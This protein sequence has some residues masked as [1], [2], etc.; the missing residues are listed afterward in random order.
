MISPKIQEQIDQKVDMC[1][2]TVEKKFGCSFVRPTIKLDLN[3]TQFI[4]QAWYRKNLI[5]LNPAGFD[6]NTDDMI[7]DTLPHEIAH[8]VTDH[9]YGLDV[10]DH[11]REWKGVASMLGAIPRASSRDAR[12][13]PDYNKT[14]HIYQCVGCSAEFAL[15]TRR[16]ITAS[17]GRYYC[18]A[19]KGQI[20]YVR[21]VELESVS[22]SLNM[23][24]QS[25]SKIDMCEQVFKAKPGMSRSQ[26]IDAFVS[27]AKCTPAGAA[28]YYATLKK[29][30][31]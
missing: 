4:G 6:Y 21:T 25:G 5:R 31:G 28:T 11:G 13:A 8:L 30:Y 18:N 20:R 2:A 12:M 10:P 22:E 26:Y 14:P 9:V 7:H 15:S 17:K 24:V 3:S 19:C 16:H 29:R 27:I 23:S 1:Y